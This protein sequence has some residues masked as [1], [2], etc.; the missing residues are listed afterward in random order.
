M[1]IISYSCVR[2]NY[3]T[4][5][6]TKMTNHLYKR[7]KECPGTL[8]DIE[9][10]DEIKEKILKNR[11]YHMPKEE[12]P[13]TIINNI[14]NN[15]TMNNYIKNMDS[16]DKIKKYLNYNDI[17][18]LSI[19]DDMENTFSARVNKLEGN[20][21]KFG[22]DIDENRLFDI[23]EEICKIRRG[24]FKKL[25]IVYDEKMKE[26]N[27]FKSGSWETLILERGLREIVSLLQDYF[28]NYYEK[29]LVM[30]IYNEPNEQEKMKYRE[31]LE[32]H[33]KLLGC[34]DLPPYI[35]NKND[36]EILGEYYKENVDAFENKDERDKYILEEK[37]MKLYD[38]TVDNTKKYDI[39]KT[40]KNIIE[41][42]K[43][44]TK[45]N[46]KELNMKMIDL[47]NID[48]EFKETLNIVKNY[49]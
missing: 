25:N 48:E 32:S 41:I 9:L 37:W 16:L 24:D 43:N 1:E 27:L 14:Q 34:F 44:N 22:Y 20:K 40:K 19:E 23:I 17:D 13:T 38:V 36:L 2:C 21:F 10:T 35:K 6:K 11:I 15:N 7:K 31:D 29:Y 33:Y 3:S 46:M 49:K 39:N 30:K 8:N 45:R 42:L 18:L 47:L 26:L 28:L 4:N 12:K 5:H